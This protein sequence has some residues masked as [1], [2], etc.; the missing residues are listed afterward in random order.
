MMTMNRWTTPVAA[1]LLSIAMSAADA[2]VKVGVIL[3]TTGPAA[4]LGVPQKNTVMVLPK[5]SHGQKIEYIYLDDASDTTAARQSAEKAV[6]EHKVDVIVGPSVTPTSLAIIE[7]AAKSGTPMVAFG[8]A[9]VL[10]EPVNEQ[11]AWVFKT[12]FSD[13]HMVNTVVKHMVANGVKSVAFIAFNDAFGEGWSTELKRYAEKAG[14]KVL[15]NERYNRTDTSVTAQVIKMMATKPDAVLIAGAGTPAVLPQMTLLERGYRGKIYQSHGVI[16]HDFLRVGGK[17]V[18]GTLLPASPIIAGDDLAQDHPAKEASVAYKKLYE[19]AYGP[20][21]VTGFGANVYDAWLLIDN[22]IPAA[23]K[24]GKPG[25]AEFRKGLRD[26]MENTRGLKA[27]GGII[28]MSN[29]DHLGFDL[30]APVMITIKDG[31]W[32]LVK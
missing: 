13:P 11:K 5:E 7:V 16:S 12:P 28:N 23:L 15:A 27:T 18:E 25:S 1:I 3:S 26:G 2:Q 10:I 29:S 4:S 20:G 6:S 17:N 14:I 32:T 9:A 8:S 22:A 30:N 21:S 24:A 19:G 31:K